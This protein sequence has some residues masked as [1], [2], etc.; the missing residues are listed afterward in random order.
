MKNVLLAHGPLRLRVIQIPGPSLDSFRIHL[1]NSRGHEKASC[2]TQLS[3]VEW[4]LSSLVV[5]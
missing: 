2:C 4:H 3:I 5:G 1:Q